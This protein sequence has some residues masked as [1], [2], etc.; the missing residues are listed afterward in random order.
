MCTLYKSQPPSHHLH[1]I[2]II[3]VLN[4]ATDQSQCSLKTGRM[5]W[6]QF[7]SQ[8]C[9]PLSLRFL[10]K[11]S[12]FPRSL[13][14][15]ENIICTDVTNTLLKCCIFLKDFFKRSLNFFT[16][17]CSDSSVESLKIRPFSSCFNNSS[18][19]QAHRKKMYTDKLVKERQQTV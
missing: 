2:I 14:K 17:S 4:S 5:C 3:I 8:R 16:F 9:S 1:I 11:T 18:K 10:R 19:L 12:S 13:G 7:S 6:S 15:S